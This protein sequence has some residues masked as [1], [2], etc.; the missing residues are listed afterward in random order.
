MAAIFQVSDAGQAIGVGLL[1]GIKD[2]RIPTYLV[3]IAYWVI[4][5]PAGYLL[6]VKAGLEVKGIWIGFIV[7]LIF[8][9]I[10]TN[11]RFLKKSTV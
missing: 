11:K 8:S 5:L 2:V 9:A 7:G 3:A 10:V 6:G 1:R 4:G